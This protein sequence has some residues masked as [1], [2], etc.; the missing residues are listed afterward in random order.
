MK[1]IL[2]VDDAILW[3]E[4]LKELIAGIGYRVLEAEGPDAA[5]DAISQ[6]PPDLILLDYQ[7][8]GIDGAATAR[9]IRAC[10]GCETV[11]III[12]SS[13]ELPG[14]CEETPIPHVNGFLDKKGLYDNL[15][16]CMEHH[17]AA[18]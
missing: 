12:V 18:T 2:I 17:L 8:P 3:R 14:G 1:T 13:A 7:M 9:R 4:R 10:E 15:L 5:L 6:G 11:P 16:R